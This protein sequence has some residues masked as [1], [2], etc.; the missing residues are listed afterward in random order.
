MR[1]K[2]KLLLASVL[3]AGL[4]VS[5]DDGESRPTPSQID[6]TQP[7]RLDLNAPP[8]ELLSGYNLF[9]WDKVEGFTFHEDVVPYDLNTALFTDYALKSRAIYVPKGKSIEY[10]D[11][12]VFDFPV[13]S[14]ILKTFYYPA[15][16]RKPTENISLIETRVLVRH[17]NG[18]RANPYVWNEDQTDAVLMVSGVVQRR[19]FINYD[20]E[21]QRADYLVP[22]RNQC[23]T[24]HS[25]QAT[26][27][28]TEVFLPIGPKAR[29]INRVYDYG[30][31]G[32]QNQLEYFA[33]R[34]ILKGL[35]PIAEVPAAYDFRPIE[36]EGLAGI[37][38]ED[39]EVA[40]RDY[41][42]INCAHCHSPTGIQGI[43][44]QLFLNY[45]NMDQHRLGVC[46]KPG[47]AATASGGNDFDIVPGDP[48]ASI[49]HFRMDTTDSG[50]MMP[51]LGRSVTHT[52][53]VELIHAWIA[54]MEHSPICPPTTGV[55][56]TEEP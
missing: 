9:A 43:T 14:L 42:D 51:R 26:D 39:V 16:L 6:L 28:S 12:E 15:D 10:V 18:W 41:L 20:G 27:A 11:N 2:V 19:S 56:E 5:C 40:A 38:A 33:S 23:Q 46:K 47:S 52:E 36:A 34:G 17:E 48:E 3:M 53:G 50:K 37:P 21:T 24:C 25:F 54:G 1:S 13:G 29:H 55:E 32:E 22:Q 7:V 44:S 31:D 45:D 8:P 30:A 4:V 49:L 35:P